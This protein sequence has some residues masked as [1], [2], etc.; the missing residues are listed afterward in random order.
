MNKAYR[1][2]WSAARQAWIV[3]SEQAGSGGRPSLAVKQS[4]CAM[5]MLTGLVSLS[6]Q[7]QDY[8]GTTVSGPGVSQTLVFGDTSDNVLLSNNAQQYVS[9]GAIATRTQATSGADQTIYDG[10]Y[11]SFTTVSGE[12]TFQYVQ[13]GGKAAGTVVNSQGRQYV[14][15]GGTITNTTLNE[16]GSLILT[17]KTSASGI[18]IMSRARA[19][20]FGASAENVMLNTSGYLSAEGGAVVTGITQQAGGTLSGDTSAT[21]SGINRLGEFAI[22]HG[23]AQNL[24]LEGNSVF[25]VLSANSLNNTTLG[26]GART[27]V[28]EGGTAHAT[29]IAENAQQIV[30]AG[31]Q[32][33]GTLITSG[34]LQTI[35]AGGV[36]AFSTLDGGQEKVAGL[37]IGTSVNQNGTQTVNAGGLAAN[38]IL[39]TTGIQDVYGKATSALVNVGATQYVQSGGQADA[40]T[41]AGGVQFVSAGGTA[42]QSVINA[43]G[44]LNT[45]GNVIS[46]TLNSDAQA[47]IFSGAASDSTIINSGGSE[48]VL[49]GG[50][51]TA[52]TLNKNGY[53]TVDFNGRVVSA[54]VAGGMQ[55]VWGS[56]S[57]TTLLSGGVQY[58]NDGGIA[59]NTLITS[60]TAQG[61]GGLASLTTIEAQGAQYV[62]SGGRAKGTTVKNSGLMNV[63]SGGMASGTLIQSGGTLYADQGSIITDVLLDTGASLKTTTGATLSGTNTLGAFAVSAGKA[64]N[65][66]LE[67]NGYLNV[68]T[69]GSSLKTVLNRGGWESVGGLATGTTVNSSGTQSVRQGGIAK[70]TLVNSGGGQY[71]EGTAINTTVNAGGQ[72]WV[73]DG[74]T[75]SHA[76]IKRDALLTVTSGGTAT[77][78]V[79][80]EG[81]LLNIADGGVLTLANNTFV[82]N[83]MTTYDTSTRASL[84]TNITGSGQLTKNGTGTLT[85]GGHFSQS[86]VNLNNGALVMDGLQASTT[87]IAKSGTTL[88]LVNNTSLTGIIDPTDVNIDK[89]STWTITGDSLVD[90]LTHAGTIVFAPSSGA[91]IPHTLTAASLSGNDGT[92]TLNTVAGNSQSLTDKLIIDGGKAT[93]RTNLRILNR[94]GL[95]ALT[96]GNGIGVVQAVNGATTETGAFRLSQP[97]V[98]GAYNY[99]LYRNV[100][101]SWYL[102]SQQIPASATDT[103]I[104][105]GTTPGV[106]PV[107][108]PATVNYRDGMW[109]YAAL[110]SLS[111][112]YDRLMAGSADTR[113]H[114]AAD[115]RVWGRI[116][117]GHL[118]HPDS[119][120]LTDN[121]VPESSSAYSFAQLG[122]DLWQREGANAD[123]KAGMYGGVGLMRS[124]VWRDGGTHAAGTDR[125]TVYS[126]GTYLSGHTQS[127]LRLDGVLQAS[128]HSLSVA[129]NDST[130]LST[131]GTG[132]LASAEVGQAFALTDKFALEPQVQYT[133][134]GLNL[135]DGEDNAA[136]V[137]WSD[138]RRQAVRAGVK[139]ST[140]LDTKQTIAWWVTPSVMQ[141]F[142]GHSE[143]SAAVPG[144]TGSKA[145]F[146][147]TLSGTGV[148]INGGVDAQ[149]RQN[150]TLGV[151]T[152]WSDSLHG[153]E[154]GGY[155][156]TV[157]LGVSFR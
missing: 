138:S 28:L 143:V 96:T 18:V 54:T 83:G 155:Y 58:V 6:A 37:A 47:F 43:G 126:V 116:E 11:A 132:W 135:K 117:A 90:A 115:S 131:H 34:G 152:G 38:T 22:S 66:L 104:K 144:V 19:D 85:L 46:A 12:K 32:T 142:N 50:L 2:V 151:Q 81:G 16:G 17:P 103:G 107:T 98:A 7:A 61:V 133:V 72:L 88:S 24:V 139:L 123:W 156:G 124:D 76:L 48:H 100:D 97:L 42:T 130:R 114:Y 121:S 153:S 75:A 57:D 67:N 157:K 52:A 44:Q 89:S 33:D 5:V 128:H 91:F 148:G 13:S 55:Q 109:S 93:G 141:T 127:G 1:I 64:S 112:D 84:K 27:L 56:A 145:S 146:R 94:G 40:T 129:S 63:Q 140:P 68:E 70:N 29:R 71:V 39:N 122:G 51:S 62:Y 79:V 25:S 36:G 73:F 149:I 119:G 26:S 3:A 4:A 41:V 23:V 134:Q 31:G 20:I 65:V 120:R 118:H 35:N 87:I 10:G 53:Q 74:G 147:N 154:S 150:V 86:Q 111:L 49:S 60:N 137:S 82:N 78:T 95:G 77:D 106:S 102:T 113:F 21:L 101:E 14:Y 108:T 80:S 136:A 30:Y 59:K 15:A 8:V 105:P 99:T 9:S 45:Y 125:D 92:I 69:G 110:P